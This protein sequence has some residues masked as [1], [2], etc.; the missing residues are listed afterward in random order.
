MESACQTWE[1]CMN[2]DPKAVGR[3][4]V[5]AETLGEALNGFVEALTWKTLVRAACST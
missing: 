3:A 2:V 1:R 4:R 5:W